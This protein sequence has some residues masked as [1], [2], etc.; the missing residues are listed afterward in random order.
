GVLAG[1]WASDRLAARWG[2]PSG[3]RAPGLLGFPLAAFATAIGISTADPL[4]SALLLAAAAGMAALGVAPAW[5]VSTEIG[6]VHAGVVGGA[7]NTFGNL[8]GALSP[9][10]VGV[11]LERWGSWQVPLLSVAVLYLVAAICW[12]RVDPR[13]RLGP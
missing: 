11:C 8:G 1:G 5:V 4:T 6:G 9:V 2:A 3:R 13:E 7:M 10:I 12:L